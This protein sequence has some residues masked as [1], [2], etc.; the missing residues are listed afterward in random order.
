MKSASELR[1]A[2]LGAVRITWITAIVVCVLAVLSGLL[3]G[4]DG[5]NSSRQFPG[6]AF[7]DG[8]DSSQQFPGFQQ[9]PGLA[10]LDPAAA[11]V[12]G[13]AREIPP[14]TQKIA[15]AG[16]N[17]NRGQ[18]VNQQ[19]PGGSH[20]RPGAPP[21]GSQPGGDGGRPP[22]SARGPSQPQAP[23]PR[24]KPQAPTVSPPKLPQA[25]KVTVNV[26]KPPLPP[27]VSVSAPEPSQAPSGTS[28]PSLPL[29]QVS[30][31]V[32]A[33]VQTPL[34]KFPDVSVSLP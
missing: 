22:S 30:V 13:D 32:S 34:V 10:S 29:P 17:G 20:S 7:T 15:T 9:F 18:R 27:T 4:T 21:P 31:N 23:T 33:P 19:A 11:L 8:G 25:P 5:R 6:F 2:G 26:P 1:L 3:S 24:P 28:A 16:P 12:G 14:K